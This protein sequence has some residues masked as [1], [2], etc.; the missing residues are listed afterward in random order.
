MTSEGGRVATP[1][2]RAARDTL[3][4]AFDDLPDGYFVTDLAGVVRDVNRA[5]ARL[6]NS[7]PRFLAGKPLAALVDV[8]D[9]RML[10]ERI[11]DLRPD[12]PI[13]LELRIRPRGGEPMWVALRAA[14]T[15]DGRT[16]LWAARDAHARHLAASALGR[17]QRDLQGFHAQRVAE[18][19]RANDDNRELLAR[20]RRLREELVA[21]DVAKDRLIGVLSHDLRS[22][23]HA[24]LGWT[25]LLRREPLHAKARD[26]ALATIESNARAQ[27]RLL[28]E[29]LCV[30]RIASES[31]QLARACVDLPA[32]VHRA[33]EAAHARATERG[34]ELVSACTPSITIMG[35]RERLD[36][37]LSTMLAHAVDATPAGGR[38]GIRLD[39]RGEHARLVLE[40]TGQ[41]IPPSCSRRC[42]TPRASRSRP[43]PARTPS[44]CTSCAASSS[45]TAAAL[46]RRARAQGGGRASPCS[47]RSVRCNRST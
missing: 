39:I 18:L 14:L 13:E 34:V 28:D 36:H 4:V 10:R 22:P 44:V 21:A 24:V 47:C 8:A 7:E 40:D 6:V 29:L 45:F 27:V 1:C 11:A 5:A 41:G 46:R 35:D 32:L 2:S 38:V 12:A 9:A 3:R 37:A 17:S 25:Q 30:S 15:Q 42:S 26:L 16:V 43:R 23:L 19:E 20:E 31:L 33:F